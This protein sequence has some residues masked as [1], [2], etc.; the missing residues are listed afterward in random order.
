MEDIMSRGHS[1]NFRAKHP[2]DLKIDASVTDAITAKMNDGGMA[3][4]IAHAIA[5]ELGVAPA[6]V[7]AAMDLQNGRIRACQLGLFGYGQGK[8]V[9]DERSV[10][11]PELAVSIQEALA[12][13]RLP[14]AEAW[15]IA[16][17]HGIRRLEMGQACESLGVKINA[18]QLGAF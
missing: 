7:G 2:A 9:T 16:A 4:K 8:A 3:C 6:L 13:G 11:P 15:R 1:G 10:V 17:A 14:C 5:S 18:C 12:D